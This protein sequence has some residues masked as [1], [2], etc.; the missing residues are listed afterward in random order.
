M[1]VRWAC[2]VLVATAT[3]SAFAANG[4]ES[5]EPV[6]AEC[7]A[8]AARLADAVVTAAPYPLDVAALLAALD[9]E[10]RQAVDRGAWPSLLP[11]LARPAPPLEPGL[12]PLMARDRRRTALC[13][14]MPPGAAAVVEPWFSQPEP[15]GSA[16]RCALL[17]LRQD[18]PAFAR[19][20]ARLLDSTEGVESAELLQGL[21]PLLTPKERVELLPTLAEATRRDEPARDWLYRELCASEPARSEPTCADFRPVLDHDAPNVGRARALAPH[22]VLTAVYALGVYLWQRRRGPEAV[23]WPLV[24]AGASAWLLLLAFETTHPA[25][26]GPLAHVTASFARLIIAPIAVALGMALGWVLVR[27]ARWSPAGVTLVEALLYAVLVTDY[28]FR[29]W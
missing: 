9:A 26:G 5:F 7:D 17:L 6:P 2:V 11:A 13:A 25:A 14:L 18:P 3:R 23:P 4:G 22:Y 16:P 21:L 12:Q 1:S 29:F 20:R 28:A 24:G 8:F 19:L 10:C 15:V 27:L